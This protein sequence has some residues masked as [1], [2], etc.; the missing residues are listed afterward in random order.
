MLG[1]V[2]GLADQARSCEE[3]DGQLTHPCQNLASPLE[4]VLEIQREV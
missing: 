1:A 3:H 4:Q 2:E